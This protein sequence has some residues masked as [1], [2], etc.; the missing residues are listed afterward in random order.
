MA[1]KLRM[2]LA[3]AQRIE[4]LYDEEDGRGFE[5]RQPDHTLEALG[6]RHPGLLCFYLKLCGKAK[7]PP[8]LTG[9]F[10]VAADRAHSDVVGLL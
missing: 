10:V 8:L 6:F 3:V 1:F 9:F 5:S 4:H 2:C 7:T